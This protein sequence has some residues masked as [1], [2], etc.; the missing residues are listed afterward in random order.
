M[1]HSSNHWDVHL[2][3]VGM[4]A[5]WGASWPWSRA[6]VQVLPPLTAAA[7]RFLLAS[8]VLL[9]WVHQRH[10][11]APLYRLQPRQW[12]G[13]GVSAAFGVLAYSVCFMMALQTVP[14]GRASVVIALNPVATLL[15][16][17]W[18]FGER[19]NRWI[20]IGMV[21][22]VSGALISLARGN[23]VQLLSG[24]M[25]WGE[26][27]LLG[28][29]L[30]WVGYTLTGRVL[31][32]GIDALVATTVTAVL[33]G[34]MLVLASLWLEGGAAWQSLAQAPVQLWL[35]LIGLAIG[36]TVLGYVW[37]FD[38]VKALGA[39][40]ASAYIVLVPVFGVLLSV[41]WFDEPMHASLIGGALLAVSG[42]ALMHAGRTVWDRR[43]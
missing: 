5:L 10:G 6:V 17:V 16:A 20:V 40:N 1:A 23:P 28:C 12:L 25:G 22:A 32:G 31:L 34:G 9:L 24:G 3:L 42:L 13:L 15:F 30:C 19:I 41:W 39:G 26:V 29:V 21:M 33:G 36:A 8:V 37:Y 11:L 7:V 38:G 14:S 2:R 43:A 18:L 4:A 27:L 35:Y